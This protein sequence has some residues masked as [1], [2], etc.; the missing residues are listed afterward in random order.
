MRKH[1]TASLSACLV[2]ASFVG[3]GEQSQE[4]QV[5]EQ[6]DIL[7]DKMS[8]LQ[9]ADA[10]S[11]GNKLEY[12]LGKEVNGVKIPGS[13]RFEAAYLDQAL[14]LIPLAEEIEKDGT[15]LQKESANAIIASIRA[16]E[17]AFLV[18]QA[19]RAFQSGVNDV[20]ALRSKVGLLRDIQAL[21]NTVAGDRSE[22]I[23]TYQNGL[24]AGGTQV[25]GINQLQETAST[26]AG[27]AEEAS[28]DLAEYNGQIEDLQGK[29]A[30]YE[31]LELK[32]IGQARSS[33]STA[34]FD[35]LD[36]AT[37]AAKEAET[38]QAQAQKFEIDAW[39]AERVANLAEFKRQQLAGDKQ[40]STDALMGKI[41]GFFAEASE[42]TN[43]PASS[44][45]YAGL[46]QILAQAKTASGDDVLKA[47]AFLLGMSE[48]GT[49]AAAD[50]DQRGLL[51]A[52]MDKRVKSYLGMI[53]A[54]EMKIAQIK[55]DR[56]RVAD[57]L[58]EIE[59]DRQA[60]LKALTSAFAQRDTTLQATGFDRMAS[61]IVSLKKAEQAVKASGDATDM[62][63]MSVYMLHA[64]ALHQQRVSAQ[65]YLTTLSS[66]ATAGPEL[67]GEALNGSITARAQD[68][69]ALLDQVSAS[70]D[71][72]QA[73][74]SIPAT[75]LLNLD[76]E[77]TRGQ[78]AAR[79]ME[80]YDSLMA[81]LGEG[82]TTPEIEEEE[83]ETP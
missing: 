67:L 21:N 59:S 55:L 22:I 30:E 65:L 23:A 5:S 32:L 73:A 15:P 81:S 37:A 46:A 62:E 49:A 39:I 6:L 72:L 33:Q 18:D 51:V 1:L 36:Q 20:I 61:A 35:K 11:D 83:T 13:T 43:I 31:A 27:Q 25:T 24:Q 53:G 79:Q 50:A 12:T 7:L 63:L 60:V 8:R 78:I 41:D 77:S 56:Q 58:A 52:A 44:D 4:N 70:I 47:A 17:A 45:T 76:G 2:T 69:Q 71:D 48:Y 75:T 14:T 38:A 80:I 54:L 19:E 26:V 40:S 16:D 34:K 42:E 10:P 64:R 74:A 68:M 28:Q 9:Y 29:V 66:I 57:K 3:C 82:A